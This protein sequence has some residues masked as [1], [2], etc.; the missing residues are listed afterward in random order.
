V[1]AHVDGVAAGS[2]PLVALDDGDPMS[3]SG[4]KAGEGRTG[5][6]GT[7]ALL[8]EATHAPA[9]SL[10]LASHKQLID[11]G[12]MQD[13]DDHYRATARRPV[14]LVNQRTFET[15]GVEE[16][17][18]VTLTGPLGSI[19]LP[20]GVADL[21]DGAVWA[22]ASAPGF[23]VRHLVGAAGDAVTVRSTLGQPSEGAGK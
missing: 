16:G 11:D 13:G 6:A 4:Q 2:N 8:G 14:V 22:P 17:D 1:A 23:S 10:V 3:L 5:D 9:G 20:V 12:R 21:V 15:L 19:D 18:L 7:G